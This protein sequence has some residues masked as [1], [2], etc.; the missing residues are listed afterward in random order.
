MNQPDNHP[1]IDNPIRQIAND[2]ITRGPR[3]ADHDHDSW[4][5]TR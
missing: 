5:V 3:R 4:A 1:H 2:G